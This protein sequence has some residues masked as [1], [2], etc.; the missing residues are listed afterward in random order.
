[1]A[2]KARK[3]IIRI[4]FVLAAVVTAVLLHRAI[5]NYTTGRTLE[6]YLAKTKAE[7]IPL[8]LEDIAPRCADSDNGALLWKA[9]EALF[10]LPEPAERKLTADTVGA[11]FDGKPL[12]DAA[13]R[14]LTALCEKNRRV[15]GL[16]AEAAAKPCFRYGDW[17]KG[18][19]EVE[20]VKGVKTIQATR[21]LGFDAVLQA[22]AGR[23][24]TGLAECRD[25]MRFTRKLM[26]EPMLINNLVALAEMKAL[27]VCFDRIVQGRVLDSS[28]LGAW[29]K[30]MDIASWRQPFVRFIPVERVFGLEW[31][32]RA[33]SG[34]PGDLSDSLSV[35][36]T[37]RGIDRFFYWL[38]RPL[39]RSQ[40]I[41]VH[42]RYGDVEKTADEP[43]YAQIDF[44]DKWRFVPWYYKATEVLLPDLRS[45]FMKEATLEAMM[46]ATKAGLACKI[47]RNKTGHYPEN[48]E[49]LVPDILPEL[50]IDPFTGK[51]LVYKIEN[52][53][54]LIYSLGSN[55][56]DDGGRGTYMITQLVMEKDDDWAWREK[57]K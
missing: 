18:P 7:G 3:I 9:A 31:G 57:A 50:P 17:K 42:N 27:L 28:V 2:A 33:I 44:L 22:D 38:A 5:L 56:K 30:E 8:R 14:T 4:L 37:E 21:L 13:R 20:Q 52:G 39:L 34:K 23:V 40:F 19:W 11:F 51:P 25:A 16:I 15:F 6:K 1:M 43:Y 26:G 47:Y 46:L 32:L 45:V 41:W 55:L 29:M 24:E 36:G 53:E 10:I 12:G 54:L 49:A 35:L 48:L